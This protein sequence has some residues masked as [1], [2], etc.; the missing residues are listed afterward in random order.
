MGGSFGGLPSS[1]STSYAA[2]NRSAASLTRPRRGAAPPA[3]RAANAGRSGSRPVS[4]QST[5]LPP[6]SAI[7]ARSSD[8]NRRTP[9]SDL[10]SLSGVSPTFSANAAWLIEVASITLRTRSITDSGMYSP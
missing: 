10:D 1:S 9:A 8:V 2:V 7:S 3:V 6:V 4:S 5:V